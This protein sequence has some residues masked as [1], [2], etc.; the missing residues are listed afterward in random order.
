[1]VW[2]GHTWSIRSHQATSKSKSPRLMYAAANT[3]KTRNIVRSGL[4]VLHFTLKPAEEPTCKRTTA[5]KRES[6]KIST[7][8]NKNKG[9]RNKICINPVV[10]M[11]QKIRGDENSVLTCR[12][13]TAGRCTTN[14]RANYCWIPLDSV[15][16]CGSLI[17]IRA[18]MRSDTPKSLFQLMFY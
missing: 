17:S 14:K 8:E 16:Q 7:A 1:M 11:R 4:D 12:L 5:S 6:Y 10:S 9:K 2:S 13:N 18:L 3:Q 15:L